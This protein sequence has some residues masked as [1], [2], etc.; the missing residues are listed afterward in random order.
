MTVSLVLNRSRTY[1][2]LDFVDG[3]VN[4]DLSK[5]E[6]IEKVTVK[7]EGLHRYAT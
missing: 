3:E 7:L 1:T 6:E 4:L 2:N 5:P